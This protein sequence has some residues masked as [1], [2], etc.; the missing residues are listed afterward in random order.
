M[1]ERGSTK[2]I[3]R[4]LVGLLTFIVCFSSLSFGACGEG[5][6]SQSMGS[7]QME[8]STSEESAVQSFTTTSY[9]PR[10]ID[11]DGV[12]NMRDLG[13]YN[14]DG[15]VVKQGMI[16]RS[17]RLNASYTTNYKVEITDEGKK[18]LEQLGIKT[19]IDLRTTAY[20]DNELGGLEK[21]TVGPLGEGAFLEGK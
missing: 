15:G 9:M 12:T 6:S 16:F 20:K 18:T 21:A 11:C 14:A 5:S 7:S 2:R 4:C 3:K 1:I 17:G 10:F 8:Q 13:G 19:E